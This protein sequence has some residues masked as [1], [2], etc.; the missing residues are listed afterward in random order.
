MRGWP[1]TRVSAATLVAAVG[2]VGCGGGSDQAED[3]PSPP[4]AGGETLLP[5]SG[6]S[7]PAQLLDLTTGKG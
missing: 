4:P 7:T 6:G 2:L 5:A 1:V 3:P